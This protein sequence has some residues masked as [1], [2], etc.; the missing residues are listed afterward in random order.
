M[1]LIASM[2]PPAPVGR[3]LRARSPWFFA[4]NGLS[5]ILLI[6]TSVIALGGGPKGVQLGTAQTSLVTH[7]NNKQASGFSLPGLDGA[8]SKLA[9]SDLRGQ[10]VLV[11]FWAS[12]CVPCRA[13]I[14]RLEAAF[15]KAHGGL[16]FVGVNTNDTASGANTLDQKLGVTYPSGFDPHGTAAEAYGLYGLPSTAII[17]PDGHLIERVVGELSDSAVTNLVSTM[18]AL[19]R[20]GAHASH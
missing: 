5:L 4:V 1:S 6:A 20:K 13:E 16:L 11:N 8:S 17:S 18:Q 9:L 10:P 19:Q 2:Q 12:W 3:W 7:Y 14:P 15:A